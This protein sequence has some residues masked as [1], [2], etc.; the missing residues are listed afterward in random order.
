M[1]NKICAPAL[2]N[3]SKSPDISCL[4]GTLFFGREQSFLNKQDITRCGFVGIYRE[5]RAALEQW[6]G[7]VCVGELLQVPERREIWSRKSSLNY[8]CM[9]VKAFCSPKLSVMASDTDTG[10]YN[11]GFFLFFFYLNKYIWNISEYKQA[12]RSPNITPCEV[13]LWKAEPGLTVCVGAHC[14]SR[15]V[16]SSMHFS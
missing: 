12:I 3:L 16:H 15:L 10:F 11:S 13:T 1:G 5:A 4:W 14:T 7:C 6:L 8:N 9:N 2:L